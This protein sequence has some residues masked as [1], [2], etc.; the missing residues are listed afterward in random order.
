MHRVVPA[1]LAAI[2]LVAGS[3]VAGTATAVPPS[4]DRGK[5]RF[6]VFTGKITPGQLQ[7]I[8]DLGVARD[9]LALGKTA[10]GKTEVEVVMSVSR[11]EVLRAK[12]V[13][14][15]LKKVDGRNAEQSAKAL[16]AQGDNVFRPYSG[17]GGL[18]EEVVN[19]ANAKPNI[20]KVVEIGRSLQGKPITAIRVTK[21]A[22]TVTVGSR[23]AVVFNA[24]QHAREWITTENVRRQLHYFLNGYG[25]N[26]ETTSIVDTTDLY[27][28]VVANPDGYDLT[29]DPAHRLWRKNVR[30][31]DGDGRLTTSDG[32]DPNRN[33]QYKWGYDNEGS[34][35]SPESE[36]YRGP[37]AGSEPETKALDAFMSSIRPKFQLNYHSAAG[38]LLYGVGWQANTRSADDHIFEAL[39]GDD[40][41]PAVPGYDPDLEAELYTAN[42]ATADHMAHRYGTLAVTP[43]M[44]TCQSAADA[45]PN[46]EWKA[47]DCPSLFHFP[48]DEVLI[49]QEFQNNLPLAIAT[50]KSASRPDEPVSVVGR[51]TPDLV[52][53]R[54]EVS[55]GRNQPVA[56]VA[57]R[58]LSDLQLKYRINGGTVRTAAPAEWQGGERYGDQHNTYYGEFRGTV[59]GAGPGNSVEVWF[60]AKKKGVPI[61]SQHFTYTVATDLGGDVL[62]LAAEDVTGASPVQEGAEAKYA[63]TYASALT[64][65]GYTWDVYDVDKHN[66][67]APH[68]LGVLSHYKAVVWET[69]E[70]IVTRT[71]DQPGGTAARLA[72]D[73]ELAVRDYLNEGGK[74]LFAGKYAGLAQGT[75]GGLRYAPSGP[76]CGTEGNTSC[77]PIL[78]DF[79]QYYLGAYSYIDGGGTA[80]D[81]KPH[82]VKGVGGAFSGFNSTLN[83]GD[84]ANNQDHTAAFL[85]TSSFLPPAQFPQFASSAA[86][87]WDR[88]GV[89]PFDPPTGSWYTYSQRADV[90]FK[91]LTRTVDLTGKASGKLN[92]RTSFD[93]EDGWDYIFVEAHTVGQDDWTTLPDANGHT[94]QDTGPT[95]STGNWLQ[96]YHPFVAHYY[97]GTD[98]TPTG[99]TGTWHAATAKSGGWQDW[100]IDLSAYAGKQV[101]LSVSYASDAAVQGAGL[102]VDDTTVTA[103]GALISQTSFE[104]DLGGWTVAGP[105]PGSV[106]GA[107]DWTR[108]QK[109]F[110]EG[111]G[112]TTTDTV[113][114]GFGVEGL[115]TQ[116]A[117]TDFV[118]RAMRH[119]LG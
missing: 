53:D 2:A 89:A 66:R 115:T 46:D 5:D 10:D 78:D 42:G 93:A 60:E 48:D 75:N 71:K 101:E 32:V 80:A 116:A 108:S 45:D 88:P 44:S 41:H 31:N 65:A 94:S 19:A 11:S 104:T 33:F 103:D 72:V 92:F 100:E 113:Y 81:G 86:I 3:A 68:H 24:T 52:V 25:T 61:A 29:F 38:L 35:V 47:A 51:S 34:S 76:E 110:D 54:F 84:S 1:C 15:T 109:A 17:P 62:V 74:L 77:L 18:R 69:G 91:R 6:E 98:C 59:Q 26:A 13:S 64:Q 114:L 118:K 70:D 28:L 96:F 82:P 99:T 56:V 23:P 55:H 97:N 106:P 27:F 112:V 8:R 90:S 36:S 14:L 57:R 102:F 119:L 83:G 111:A 7:Q 73:L 4:A 21:D 49:E 63:S 105:P 43:E 16:A 107:N 87:G 95:C 67:T 58:S 9:D 40:D 20:A 30:D 39:L 79:L 22:R 117:R 12:G 50:A 85:T 37:S